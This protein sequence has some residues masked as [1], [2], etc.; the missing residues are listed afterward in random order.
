MS[1]RAPGL[2]VPVSLDGLMGRRREL[3]E[4][5]RAFE[6]ADG[7]TGPVPHGD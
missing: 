4:W 5:H 1:A 3:Q 2:H 7:D 6:R